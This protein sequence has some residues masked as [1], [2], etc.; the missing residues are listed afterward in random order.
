MSSI[1]SCCSCC[2][3]L[4]HGDGL[5][6]SLFIFSPSLH[7]LILSCFL[8]L[9]FSYTLELSLYITGGHYFYLP[10]LPSSFTY[11]NFFMCVNHLRMLQLPTLFTSYFIPSSWHI[12][13]Y[14]SPP[15]YNVLLN[16][17]SLTCVAFACCDAF[18]SVTIVDCSTTSQTLSCGLSPC[19]TC[20]VHQALCAVSHRALSTIIYHA[21]P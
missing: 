10:Q 9:T 1:S 16:N 20:I 17:I 21:K 14:A 11:C 5:N 3:K 8:H 7:I 2:R 15:L 19:L 12:N 6:R 18:R 13:V 4:P